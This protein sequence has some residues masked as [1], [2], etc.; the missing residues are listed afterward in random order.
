[1]T[2]QKSSVNKK[3]KIYD[4]KAALSLSAPMSAVLFIILNIFYV[5]F[6]LTIFST[7]IGQNFK[8]NFEEIRNNY[9][10]M[11]TDSYISRSGDILKFLLLSI[12]VIAGLYLFV[13]KT[14]KKAVNIYLS[15]PVDRST[16]FMNRAFGG[17]IVPAV[18]I[19]LPIL[20]DVIINIY[21]I[22][23]P[24]YMLYGGFF[25]FLETFAYYFVGLAFSILAISICN[26]VVEALFT[27][28]AFLGFPTAVLFFINSMLNCFLRGFYTNNSLLSYSG[29]SLA[30]N[31]Y[32]ETCTYLNPLLF[33]KNMKEGMEGA[34]VLELFSRI[35][36]EYQKLGG[37]SDSYT[38]AEKIGSGNIVPIILWLAISVAVMFIA[39]K[40]YNSFKAENAGVHGSAPF[41]THFFIITC[42]LTGAGLFADFSSLAAEITSAKEIA[43]I[44]LCAVILLF[45]LY[46][47]FVV[48]NRRS[49]KQKAKIFI[50]PAALSVMFCVMT[51][52][53]N[54]GGLGYATYVPDAD[55]IDCAFIAGNSYNAAFSELSDDDVYNLDSFSSVFSFYSSSSK[56]IGAFDEKEDLEKLTDIMKDISVKKDETNGGTV[57][58]CYRLKNGEV[59]T[60]VYRTTDIS[61]CEKILSLRDTSGFKEELAYLFGLEETDKTFTDKYNDDSIIRCAFGYSNEKIARQSIING[62]IEIRAN[63]LISQ[64]NIENTTEL[65]RALYDDLTAQTYEDRIN[66]AENALGI[67]TIYA[68]EASADDMLYD[69]YNYYGDFDCHYVIYPSMTN[70]INYLKSVN[71]YDFLINSSVD[72]NVK[73]VKTMTVEDLMKKESEQFFYNLKDVNYLFKSGYNNHIFTEEYDDEY[74]TMVKDLFKGCAASDEQNVIKNLISKSTFYGKASP[75]DTIILIEYENGD[76]TTRLIKNK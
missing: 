50:I 47:I 37:Y 44:I 64:K 33:S 71:A 48:I 15:S 52:V 56:I 21:F 17:L 57:V 28:V 76:F 26:T 10:I 45:L 58:G 9:I 1:M 20:A 11:L 14:N 43:I 67:I 55:D 49:F 16:M 74:Y 29:T 70:T 62:T 46:Y 27:S 75:K 73:S 31:G 60:R 69:D 18:A 8:I 42:A 12:G 22:G 25:L 19:A 68:S 72:K 2:S 54:T 59:I 13:Y 66:P 3:S 35:T 41:A 6:P 32:V 65:R 34:S 51:C 23:N 24:S 36:P 30:G 40:V 4:F 39:R 38:G 61:A 7:H 5:Y 53:L 63:S